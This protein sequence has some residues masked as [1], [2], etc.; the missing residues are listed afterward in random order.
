[1]EPLSLSRAE[2]LAVLPAGFLFI[3]GLIQLLSDLGDTSKNS[4]H[5]KTH[6]AMIGATGALVA[7]ASL[8]V[9][10]TLASTG[11]LYAGAMT[12]DLFG[13]LG[14]GVIIVTSLFVTLMSGGYLSSSGNNKAEFHSLINFS[15]GAMV[16]L[17]QATNLVSIFVAIETLSLAVYVLAGFFKENKSASEGAF[18]YFIMGAFSSGFLLFGMALVYGLSG[19]SLSL[20]GIAASGASSD[21]LFAVGVLLVLIG[22]AFKVGVV[23]FHSWVPDVYQGAPVL[24]VGW[25]AVAV[26]SASFFALC[27]FLYHSGGGAYLDQILVALSVVTMILGNLAALNQQSLKRMLAYSG[28]AHSG[29]LMI[30]VLVALSG[31]DLSIGASL[32]FYLCAYAAT[33]LAAFGVL[34]ALSVSTDRDNIGDLNGLAKSRPML[35]LGFTIALISLAGIPLTAGFIGKLMI[36]S[37]AIGAGFIQIAIIGILTSLVS[38]YYYLRP[39]VA[40]WFR[41]PRSSFDLIPAPWGV[42]FT[43][44]VCGIATIFVGLFPDWLVELSRISV[45]TILG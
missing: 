35:A 16:L 10:G 23:P 25:M 7:F 24:A 21:A 4:R 12:D 32:P 19:G 42:Q 14:A 26:K 1:M 45:E 22:F 15:A 28:I 43:V 29:Y 20:S 30:P 31:N 18:K 17:C 8:F 37:D 40:M 39:V 11:E 2:I 5:E 36:F 41:D 38:V 6:L 9:Q 27:R 33:T 44:G 3:T 34:T 13:R